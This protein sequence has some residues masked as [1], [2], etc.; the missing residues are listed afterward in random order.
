MWNVEQMH[1]RFVLVT[2]CELK[3][4]ISNKAFVEIFVCI[5]YFKTRYSVSINF[6]N[7][8]LHVL[9]VSLAIRLNY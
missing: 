4:Y 6:L 9:E 5:L 7:N 2:N 1:G 8:Y 3:K